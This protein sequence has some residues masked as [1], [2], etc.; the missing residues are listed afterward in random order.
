ML[1][2]ELAGTA[3]QWI[4]VCCYCMVRIGSAMTSG[5]ECAKCHNVNLRFVHVLEHE[6][7]GRQI[8]VGIECA[9]MLLDPSDWEIPRLAETETQRKERWRIHY[10]KPG[11]C[12]TTF[13]HLEERGKL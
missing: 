2:Q 3:G 1:G 10:R 5:P 7:D 6:D 9:R 12:V 11:R 4:Y 13:R 8:E